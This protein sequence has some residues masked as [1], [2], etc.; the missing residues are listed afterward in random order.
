MTDAASDA[1][2]L[3]FPAETAHVS[4]ARTV[5]ASMAAQ[6]DLPLDLLED[7]RL[8]V[9]EAVSQL[10]ADAEPGSIV[11]C[12][13]RVEAAALTVSVSAATRSR[14][15]SRRGTFSWTVLTA[16]AE[17]AESTLSDG[18]SCLRLTVSRSVPVG[19]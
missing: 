3:S 12:E 9:D 4:L 1:V 13:F 15:A 2:I 18:R 16:L 7:A 10:I 19:S 17:V 14:Q 6:A 8:A 11:A 5:A